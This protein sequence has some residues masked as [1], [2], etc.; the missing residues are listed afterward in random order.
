VL[1]RVNIVYYWRTLSQKQREEAFWYR[2][3]QRY[4]K[5]SLPHFDRDGDCQY[6]FTAACYEHAPVIGKTTSRMTDFEI[7]LLQLCG[8][9]S[10]DIY[11]WCI[12]PNDYHV[13]LKTA[14]MRA[15]RQEIGK[16]HGKTSF[17]WNG[18][19]DQQGRTVWRNGFERA[20]RSPR[21]YFAS[22]NYVLNNAVHHG[23]VKK[24]QEWPWSNAS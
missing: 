24:W 3:I 23:Y 6:L 12:L 20:M 10:S 17:E 16:L 5:H 11:A 22:L 7:R 2:R 13:L 1:L 8:Q 15:L 4:P 18:E 14:V 21:H 19:D 9:F